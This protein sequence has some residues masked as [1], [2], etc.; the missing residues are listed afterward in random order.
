MPQRSAEASEV[1]QAGGDHDGDADDG[2]VKAVQAAPAP[3]VN[4][5]GQKL[6]QVI[7]VVA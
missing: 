3:T 2:G 6:G 7:N 5:S 1:K 4:T